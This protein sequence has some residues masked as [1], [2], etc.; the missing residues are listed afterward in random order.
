MKIFQTI[1]ETQSYLKS[2]SIGFVPTMGA[3]HNGHISLIKRAKQ[4]NEVCVCSIFVNPTQFNNLE[5]L[6]KYPRPLEEDLKKLKE[7]GC[8]VVF[9]PSAKEIYP[10]PTLLKFDFGDLERTL[11]GEFRPNHFNGVGIV[12]SKLFNIIQPN[13]A[14]FGQKDLQQ[15]AIINRLVKDLSFSID[16]I[17]CETVRETDGLAMSSRNTRL[18]PT[19]RNMAPFLYKT[20]VNGKEAVLAGKTPSEV[21]TTIEAYYEEE[22]DFKLE[23]YAIVDFETL[24]PIHKYSNERKTAIV[25]ASYLDGVRLID[26]IVF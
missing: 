1:I 12:V 16:L 24:I 20:L 22:P 18:R 13:Y 5:D 19:Y 25:V 17:F 15:C 3:L 8:D 4:E 14:Y 26:N 2:N 21:I 9:V 10:T 6:E 7:A 11:E 23:Y